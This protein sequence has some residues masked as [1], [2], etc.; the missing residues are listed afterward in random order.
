MATR[1]NK[2]VEIK[3]D[4][5]VS[6]K[7]AGLRYVMDT[8]PGFHPSS[9]KG[10]AF[11]YLDLD[12]KPILDPDELARIKALVIPPAWTEVWICPR[13]D[14]HLQATGRDAQGAE[15]VSLSCPVW[16]IGPRRVEV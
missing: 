13:A 9:S 5:V 15:A 3:V 8:K 14:G 4:P 7:A 2:P 16:R 6:A 1:A 10:K 11:V 12:G